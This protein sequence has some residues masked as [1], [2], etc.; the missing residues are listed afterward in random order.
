[1]F[2]KAALLGALAVISGCDV[3]DRSGVAE[4]VNFSDAAKSVDLGREYQHPFY[5]QNFA[6]EGRR[7][8]RNGQLAVQYYP[9]DPLA[10]PPQI[11]AADSN[12]TFVISPVSR[13]ITPDAPVGVDFIHIDW[14][15]FEL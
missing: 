15:S 14:F 9:V 8:S 3:E 13:Q 2:R 11:L 10:V 1:M 12:T 6:F 4:C 5:I 7:G